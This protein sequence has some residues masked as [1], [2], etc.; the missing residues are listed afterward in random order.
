MSVVSCTL[1]R[2]PPVTR[3]ALPFLPRG[4]LATRSGLPNKERFHKELNFDRLFVSFYVIFRHIS[5]E[6][7]LIA[8]EQAIIDEH[9]EEHGITKNAGG[10]VSPFNQV[11]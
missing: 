6:N 4:K 8:A 3:V 7:R 1:V 9:I 2:R 5:F 10:W 11:Q